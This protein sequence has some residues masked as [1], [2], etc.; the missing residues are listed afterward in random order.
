MAICK[1]CGC[2]NDRSEWPAEYR[3]SYVPHCCFDC[4]KEDPDLALVG[5]DDT[6]S[7]YDGLDEAPSEDE[8]EEVVD[9]DPT[10]GECE[11]PEDPE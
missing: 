11:D 8:Q 2:Y 4:Y 5:P 6:F 3:S 1:Y 10:D 9:P 7:L